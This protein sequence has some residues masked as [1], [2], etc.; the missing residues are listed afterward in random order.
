MFPQY[1]RDKFLGSLTQQC[2]ANVTGDFF[3]SDLKHD[4]HGERR[5]MAHLTMP[6]SS[7]D[8]FQELPETAYIDKSG[9]GISKCSL[10]QNMVRLV[11]TQH[12]VD[13]VG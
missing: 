12:I 13:E 4:R 5:N 6:D 3:P 2:V 10:K 1:F 11:L 9:R 8:P 7:A